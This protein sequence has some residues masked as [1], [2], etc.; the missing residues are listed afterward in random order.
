MWLEDYVKTYGDPR[1]DP[2]QMSIEWE[3]QKPYRHKLAASQEI[4]YSD[5]ICLS[6]N[7]SYA[8][9]QLNGCDS[10]FQLLIKNGK[11]NSKPISI[12]LYRNDA[13]WECLR[14]DDSLDWQLG[15]LEAGYYRVYLDQSLALSFEAIN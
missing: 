7:K 12:S 4:I 1:R 15:D 6:N 2:L 11:K 5:I 3:E 10:S 8:F 9:I 13:L 14:L